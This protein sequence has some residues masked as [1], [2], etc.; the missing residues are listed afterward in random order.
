M[1]AVLRYGSFALLFPLLMWLGATSPVFAGPS[2][3]VSPASGHPNSKV[4]VSGSG[5][6]AYEAVDIYFDTTD[7]LLVSTDATGAFGKH[8]LIVP[9]NALP[10]THWITGVGRKGGDSAQAP[11]AVTT[12]WAE[13]GFSP[14]GKRNNPYENVITTGNASNL[15]IAWTATTG[16]YVYSSPA[17]EYGLVYV[18]S[19]DGKLYAFNASTGA[20]LWTAT[21][22][23]DVLS[24]PAVANGVV[25]VGSDDGKLYAF[26]A[27]TGALLSGW[28]V[29]T[30]NF[31]YSSPA[32][33]NGVVYVGS[34]DDNLY[35]FNARTGATLWT[36]TT[37][38]QVD[39]SPAVANGVVYVGSLD[40]KLYAF[41]ATT[42]AVLWTATTVSYI[43]SS[44]AVANGVVYVG[45]TDNKVYAF[46]ASYGATLW[47]ATTGNYVESSPAV[48]DGVV[49]VGSFDDKL[50]SF[51]LEGGNN[52]VYRGSAAPPSYA[53]LHPDYRLKP[54]F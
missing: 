6:V 34:S 49:Y 54:A 46:D 45:S 30:G 2:V 9:A 29:T 13:V 42:G 44:P 10:G 8:Q 7:L 33:A 39:S 26:N 22:T 19:E 18:G 3:V 16:N 43:D 52:A 15:D 41:N 11:F 24:S 38:S 14:H 4:N 31:I 17:V 1:K 53:S 51:A 32:V 23:G 12:V 27:N 28:P 20:T 47:T 21:T 37:G 5:F 35:A 25:Y 50:Y 36:A 48:S 40:G